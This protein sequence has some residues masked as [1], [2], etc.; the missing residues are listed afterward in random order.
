MATDADGDFVVAWQSFDQ[1]GSTDGIFAQRFGH[2]AP[3][4]DIDGNGSLE[5]LTDGLLVLRFLFGFT[6]ATLTTGAVGAQTARAATPPRSRP[7]SP[8]SARCSTSTATARLGALT[9]GLLVLR[10]LFG[11]TG[12][13]LTNGAVDA[14]CT[15]C[16]ATEIVP[17]LQALF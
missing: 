12:T 9:D 16:D 4:L 5:P 1:D 15:R 3:S 17:Y 8:G 2:A 13:T 11:F 10:F 7:T 6:G 14:N